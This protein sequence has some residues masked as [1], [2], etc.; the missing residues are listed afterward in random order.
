MRENSIRLSNELLTHRH[1]LKLKLLLQE[2][3]IKDDL[4][5]DLPQKIQQLR[6]TIKT[7][8]ESHYQ[9]LRSLVPELE[10][11]VGV[12]LR[13]KAATTD[14]ITLPSNLPSRV[15]GLPYMKRLV[16]LEVQIRV[17]LAH[18]ALQKLRSSLGYKSFMRRHTV[19]AFGRNEG[20]RGKQ[21]TRRAAIQVE[22][23]KAVYRGFYSA[24]MELVEPGDARLRGLKKLEDG[25]LAVLGDYLERLGAPKERNRQP[26][27]P[28][29]LPW[30]WTLP[31]LTSAPSDTPPTLN[32]NGD[33]VPTEDLEKA[34]EDW[35][36][37]G[38]PCLCLA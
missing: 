30:I 38:K 18:D 6:E 4:P 25:D 34:I 37:E 5:A 1:R 10:A 31:L 33:E 27:H 16:D 28:P 15:R 23:W 32:A 9:Q 3:K 17:G 19:K 24:L 29:S 20:T 7:S 11:E 2:A 22:K 36:W 12:N 8:L 26:N 35:N 14:P 13:P 21:A